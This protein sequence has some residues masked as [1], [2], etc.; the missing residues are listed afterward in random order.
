MKDAFFLG[1]TKLFRPGDALPDV[2]VAFDKIL[3]AMGDFRAALL[4]PSLAMAG[5][6]K[7]RFPANPGD[8]GEP[9]AKDDVAFASAAND[10]GFGPALGDFGASDIVAPSPT[11][12]AE[13]GDH[14]KVQK[15]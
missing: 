3:R 10:L 12:F 7:L 13:C 5:T 11:T 1:A 6:W 8:P 2:R 9:G 4:A 14:N 15:L